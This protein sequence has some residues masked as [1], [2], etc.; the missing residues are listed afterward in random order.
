MVE[1]WRFPLLNVFAMCL[2]VFQWQIVWSFTPF[3]NRIDFPRIWDNNY[4]KRRRP[5]KIFHTNSGG[6]LL[7]L[8]QGTC[9]DVV[10][11]LSI[12]ARFCSKTEKEHWTG[13]KRNSS[14][15]QRNCSYGTDFL[16]DSR[17]ISFEVLW[18]L[19]CGLSWRAGF[20]D[21]D[22]GICLLCWWHVDQLGKK[23]TTDTYYTQLCENWIHLICFSSSRSI[24]VEENH[25]WVEFQACNNSHLW[26]HSSM[27]WWVG[28]RLTTVRQNTLTS[29]I[30]L[31]AIT[32]QIILS[33][34]PSNIK[35]DANWLTKPPDQSSSRNF[36]EYWW[37]PR[38]NS[39]AE[40]EWSAWWQGNVDAVVLC[41]PCSVFFCFEQEKV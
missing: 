16:L 30:T 37:Y 36:L 14:S 3:D 27:T 20:E 6:R 7:Y 12:V 1:L 41:E 11:V 34:R 10:V 21:I 40:F 25:C 39:A 24:V 28:T 17:K 26:G 22:N 29:G 18:L 13:V 31:S 19:W 33:R 35:N 38:G 2:S 8:V 4:N 5:W 15:S 9:S 32:S 23:I